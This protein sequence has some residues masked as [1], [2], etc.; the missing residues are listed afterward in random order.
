MVAT[1][2][3]PTVEGARVDYTIGW[4]CRCD[5]NNPRAPKEQQELVCPSHGEHARPWRTWGAARLG[6][7]WWERAGSTASCRHG[8]VPAVKSGL[9]VADRGRREHICRV[10]EALSFAAAPHSHA[11][12]G[13]GRRAESNAGAFAT[14]TN[15]WSRLSAG[16]DW[17]NSRSSIPVHQRRLILAHD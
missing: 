5:E 17:V 7:D 14:L 12:E 8:A 2:R 3:K 6:N 4:C 13:S 11:G 9:R 15:E 1:S 10:D 16:C